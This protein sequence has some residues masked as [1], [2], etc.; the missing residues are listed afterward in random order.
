MHAAP[1]PAPASSVHEHSHTEH[2]RTGAVVEPSNIKRFSFSD[3][4][5]YLTKPNSMYTRRQAV[6]AHS[7]VRPV[8]LKHATGGVYPDHFPTDQGTEKQ[9]MICCRCRTAV[10]VEAP[11]TTFFF[12]FF[13]ST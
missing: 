9:N 6:S 5:L 12:L 10:V 8:S 1:M 7:N 4:Y 13:C 11:V 3:M 2:Y